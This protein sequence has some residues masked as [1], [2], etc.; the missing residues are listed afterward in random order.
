MNSK[1]EAEVRENHEVIFE[2]T[3]TDETTHDGTFTDPSGDKLL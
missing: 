2:T 1:S 3:R